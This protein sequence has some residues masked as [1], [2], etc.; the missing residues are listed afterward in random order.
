MMMFYYG[1]IHDLKSL[2]IVSD[3]VLLYLIWGVDECWCVVLMN[4]TANFI[5]HDGF[6]FVDIHDLK[7]L[8]ISDCVAVPNLGCY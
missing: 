8:L 4:C 5:T 6:N 2:I 7:S 3:D 1:D